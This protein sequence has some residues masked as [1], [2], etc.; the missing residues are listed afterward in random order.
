MEDYQIRNLT[1]LEGFGQELPK[2][3]FTSVSTNLILH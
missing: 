2:L 3:E 1:R